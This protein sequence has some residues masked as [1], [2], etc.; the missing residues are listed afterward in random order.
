MI[1]AARRPVWGFTLLEAL[2]IIALVVILA[3]LFFPVT[4]PGSRR[5]PKK[6]AQMEEVQIAQAIKSYQEDHG[7]FPVSSNAMDVAAGSG[8]DFTFGTYGLPS[9]LK[10]PGGTY[11]VR[12]LDAA[13]KPLSYQGNNS[14]IMAV[15]LDVEAW[16]ASP[17][18]PDQ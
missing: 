5:A 3:V 11:D 4:G 2:L 8:Q 9:G 16:P 17:T 6:E 18:L 13:A 10:M 14:E 12:A 7:K 15:L 1:P